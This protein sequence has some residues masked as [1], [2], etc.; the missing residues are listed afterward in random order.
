MPPSRRPES[1]RRKSA[2]IAAPER[3]RAPPEQ[4]LYRAL[5]EKM[6]IPLQSVD[7]KAR[8]LAVNDAWLKLL[9]YAR[10]DVIGEPLTRFYMPG[11]AKGLREHGWPT[12]LEKGEI[13]NLERHLRCK[14]GAVVTVMLS[15]SIERDRDGQFLRSYGALVDVTQSRKLERERERYFEM[16]QDFLTIGGFDGSIRDF[17]PAV[18]A[19]F[20]LGRE[21][22]LATPFW[23]LLH[24]DDHKAV[25]VTLERLP[26]GAPVVETEARFRHRD[27]SWHSGLW[28][29]TADIEEKLIFSVGRDVHEER[30]AQDVLRRSERLE[31]I[32]QLTGGVAHDFNNLLTIVIGNLD[33]IVGTAAIDDRVRHLAEAALEGAER[34]AR[35]T[36]HLLAFARRQRLEP[37]V[38]C[39]DEV[40]C[41]METLYRRAVGEAIQ[42]RFAA[43]P[44]LWPCRADPG[45]LET[46]LLNL[47]LNARD[48]MTTGG[49]LTVAAS[50][51]SVG[52]QQVAELAPGDYLAITV[53]DT[54]SGMP[55]EVLA[56]AFEPF[57]STKPVGQGS[58]LGLS[59]VYGFA[60]QSGGTA[61]IDSSPG[62]GTTVA[63]YLPRAESAAAAEAAAVPSAA[64]SEKE[65]RAAT[66]L[67]VEDEPAVRQ[68]TADLLRDLGHRVLV[69]SDG[70]EALQVPSAEPLVDLLI[71]DVVMPGGIDG[72]A[73]A[74]IARQA[75]PRL[76]V[77]LVSGYGFASDGER[78]GS[79]GFD[80]LRKPYRP[81][82]L[83]A[84]VTEV[85]RRPTE[86]VSPP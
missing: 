5:F 27:G 71:S 67:V 69:A 44:D 65:A 24:P 85:L 17:N 29:S 14:S 46:V 74:V 8:L 84:K 77:L 39:L 9:G 63:L 2:A 13:H 49:T 59:M 68:I 60:R 54:G 41:R 30:Q 12:L 80:V 57:F 70:A 25:G 20:G 1:H 22:M 7:E 52:P 82:Q 38:L 42:L 35:L 76:R 53:E 86:A 18:L 50:N 64:A 51:A 73:L 55:A 28:R 15:G 34:G 16:A 10:E 40:L 6:P 32:G 75:R 66:V 83:F 79:S 31:A 36:E 4:A 72:T 48:A 37:Q 78:N 56:R 23:E 21:Q 3:E 43:A 33:R 61:R 11:S 58:G 19:A 45:R 47:I 26:A 81:G 62:A